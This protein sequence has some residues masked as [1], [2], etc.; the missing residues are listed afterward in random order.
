MLLLLAGAAPAQEPTVEQAASYVRRKS[1]GIEIRLSAPIPPASTLSLRNLRVV[2]GN[3]VFTEGPVPLKRRGGSGTLF[4]HLGSSVGPTGTEIAAGDRL[5]AVLELDGAFLANLSVTVGTGGLPAPLARTAPPVEPTPVAVATLPP[6]TATAPPVPAASST[7]PAE[8]AVPPTPVPPTA[9][10]TAAPPVFPGVTLPIAGQPTPSPTR[11]VPT[12]TVAAVSPS[13][14]VPTPGAGDAADPGSPGTPGPGSEATTPDSPR[15]VVAPETEGA[16]VPA[17]VTA[18][19]RGLGPVPL[20]GG[21]LVVLGVVAGLIVLLRRRSSPAPAAR[22]LTAPTGQP[23]PVAQPAGARGSGE[24]PPPAIGGIE[25]ASRLA[26]G[27]LCD[28]YVV[29]LADER[30][31]GALKV[32]RPEFRMSADLSENLRREGEILWFLSENYPGEVFV[33]IMQQGTFTDG[34]QQSPYLVLE[35]VDGPNLRAWVLSNGA[36]VP[37]EAL[38]VTRCVAGGLSCLHAS[39]LIH[40]DISPENVL[41]TSH[42][43]AGR[44]GKGEFRLIDFGDARRFDLATTDTEIAGKPSFISPEQAAGL[45]ATPASDVYSLGMLLYFLYTGHAAFQSHHPGEVLRMH[46]VGQV[47][48]PTG[49]PEGVRRLV[50]T[51]CRKSPEDRPSASEVVSL[52]EQILSERG[53]P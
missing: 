4:Q 8:P 48:F 9:S 5:E 49:T 53:A 13:Q 29:R 22:P 23:R 31:R 2:P 30:R 16:S 51:M 44:K 21:G 6:P 14:A 34:G 3:R 41:R 10:P 11:P 28:I 32:L 19:L 7:P 25:V 27:G 36:M 1:V 47:A 40:G 35:Y 12:P 42:G 39:S 18:F 37:D 45:S 20:A 15:P 17:R 38:R 33:D 24:S 43:S 46:R 50:L 52:I 26:R